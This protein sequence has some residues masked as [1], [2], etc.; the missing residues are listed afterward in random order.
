M[1]TGNPTRSCQFCENFAGKL[2]C[3]K[4][5]GAATDFPPF[6]L[7]DEVVVTGAITFR[8]ARPSYIPDLQ[9]FPSKLKGQR[10][11]IHKQPLRS[12]SS[13]KGLSVASPA[14]LLA[15]LGSW[16]LIPRKYEGDTCPQCSKGLLRADPR[17]AKEEN[18]WI[19][20]SRTCACQCKFSLLFSYDKGLVL[21]KIAFR[22]Q[23][24]C[25]WLFAHK[26]IA[27]QVAHIMGFN[28]A[29][30]TLILFNRYMELVAAHQKEENEKVVVGKYGDLEGCHCEADEVAFRCFHVWE[31]NTWKVE[32]LRWIC[33]VRRGSAKV[34]LQEL[35]PRTVAGRG[36][37]GALSVAEPEKVLRVDTGTHCSQPK[38]V[39][40]TDSAKAYRKVG[41]L[42]WPA[43]GAL[44]DCADFCERFS[45][46]GWTRTS[47][48]HERKPGR[49]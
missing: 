48:V 42:L 4:V 14:K 24:K 19:R 34:F 7:G 35:E 9:K 40:H 29:S 11:R 15:D 16:G 41:P 23:V 12:R 31:E 20:C 32:W 27:E 6:E 18:I 22:T 1:S 46:F 26:Y 5:R 3:S 49:S 33:L 28:Y 37:G 36:G 10:V 30:T 38:C 39:L 43:N 47:V 17:P 8:R 21:P 13:L 44:Q 2:V 45:R 25:F